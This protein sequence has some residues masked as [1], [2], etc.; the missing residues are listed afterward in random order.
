[1]LCG[2]FSRISTGR[3]YGHTPSPGRRLSCQEEKQN[4]VMTS[5][6]INA[7]MKKDRGV[8]YQKANGANT[9]FDAKTVQ[10]RVTLRRHNA[11]AHNNCFNSTR[12][13]SRVKQMFDGL[14]RRITAICYT[15]GRLNPIGG[16]KWKNIKVGRVTKKY[17]KVGI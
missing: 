8:I 4:R 16:I 14:T 7:S 6:K 12:G 5:K 3:L 17:Q 11:G 9:A 10:K 13:S 15:D 1:M 2:R